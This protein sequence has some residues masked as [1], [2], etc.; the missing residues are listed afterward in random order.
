MPPRIIRSVITPKL[1][2]I[3]SQLPYQDFI[4]EQ[5]DI[6][7]TTYVTILQSQQEGIK[8]MANHSRLVALQ[9]LEKEKSAAK[10]KLQTQMDQELNRL[11]ALRKVN[12]SIRLE[13]IEYLQETTE[14]LLEAIEN[15]D[16]RMDALRVIV[17][18]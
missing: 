18:A 8:E 15:A 14:M 11:K 16:V 7:V 3:S 12:N 17:A 4:T 13:E 2:D 5:L 6:P 1:A 9:A 10:Q